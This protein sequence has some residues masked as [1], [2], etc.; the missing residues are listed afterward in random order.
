MLGRI[1]IFIVSSVWLFGAS[2]NVDKS[3]ITQGEAVTLTLSASGRDIQFP[4]IDSI[5]GFAITSTGRS[6]QTINENGKITRISNRSYMFYPDKNVTIPPFTILVDQQKESTKALHVKIVDELSLDGKKQLEVTL[7]VDNQNPYIGELI[8]ATITFRQD[9]RVQVGSVD[10]EAINFDAF[11]SKNEPIKTQ[12]KENGYFT[13]TISYW[14]S[15]LKEGNQTIGPVVIKA[16]IRDGNNKD[17]FGMF[18][19]RLTPKYI[20]SQKITLDVKP[21]PEDVKLVGSFNIMSQSD[22]SQVEAGKP[23]NILVEIRGEGNFDDIGS[24]PIKAGDAIIYDDKPKIETT[25]TN[26]GLFGVFRQKFAVIATEDVVVE[27]FVIRYFDKKSGEIKTI[28]TKPISIKVK[29]G[30]KKSAQPKSQIVLPQKQKVIVKKEGISY[31]W[32]GF[33]LFVGLLLGVLFARFNPLHVKA[34]KP[35]IF[36]NQKELLRQILPFKGESKILDE[37][38]GLLEKNIYENRSEK[39]DKKEI[40]KI[41][42]E[43]QISQSKLL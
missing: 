20:R 14:L 34:K 25:P 16:G 9:E 17:P 39:V 33:A 30:V 8:K 4:N 23:A 24:L 27:P 40:L 42:G 28:Q 13:Q 6:S 35:K 32:V 1:L 31:L 21:L 12:K 22:T 7:E 3:Q 41:L 19:D 15:P 43:L 37:Q 5:D 18:F 38:I 10:M 36:Q 11:W 2:A 26:E 29:G